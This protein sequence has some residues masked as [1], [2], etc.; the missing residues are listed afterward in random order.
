MTE[1]TETFVRRLL[2]DS[3]ELKQLLEAEI[4]PIRT[5]NDD[6]DS[7]AG[8]PGSYSSKAQPLEPTDDKKRV[9]AIVAHIDPYGD[10]Q[11]W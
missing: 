5:D 3:E 10:E 11:G 6:S 4:A 8:P 7:E 1:T 9:L 2:R